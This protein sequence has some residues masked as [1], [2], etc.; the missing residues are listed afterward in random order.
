MI[1]NSPGNFGS[2][3][4]YTD[5]STSNLSTTT[6]HEIKKR[7]VS[8]VNDE[9]TPCQSMPR[10]T[11]MNTCI[12]Q[13]IENEIGCQLPW[14]NASSSVFAKCTESGQYEKFLSTYDEI[15]KLSERSIAERT[16]C[17]PSCKRNEFSV[18]ILNRIEIPSEG[19]SYYSG[20]FCYASGRY[21][22][23]SYYYVYDW[24]DLLA[25]VGGY[26]GL[27]VGYSLLTVYDSIK[28]FCKKALRRICLTR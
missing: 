7:V 5:T 3:F 8:Y 25:D 21:V 10:K 16:G 26:M 28:Y 12:Q 17:L 14:N 6:I 15:A 1:H 24:F 18:N 23:K 27:L 22:E 9:R 13:Q 2:A 4:S 20:Y 19:P 11:E